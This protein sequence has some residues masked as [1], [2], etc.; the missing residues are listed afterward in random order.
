M[1]RKPTGGTKSLSPRSKAADRSREDEIL[2]REIDDAVRQ[3]DATRFLQKYGV[4]L[5]VVIAF[6]LAAML[7]YW[8]YDSSVEAEY[9]SQSETLIQA[10][11]NVGGRDFERASET[12]DPLLADGTSGART[13]ARFLQ[14]AA[15][16]EQGET[17][18]A[19]ELFATIVNDP[20][21][22]EPLRDLALVRQV[23]VQFD[24]LEPGE[25]ISRLE[26]LAIPGNDFF[27]SAGELV[28][29]AHLEAG[30]R[31]EAGTLFAAI[32]KDEELPE[33]LRSRARQMAGLLGVDAIEDVEQLL[34]QQ[35][36]AAPTV[37]QGSGSGAAAGQGAQP[38]Q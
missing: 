22:P 6:A 11:D 35:Q 21:T 34:E 28:A 8:W 17:A 16:I 26:G 31:R 29:I 33:T 13:S 19:S 10:L 25:V 5:G 36:V 2:M 32:A 27:G 3:D 24:T 9:E 38:P 23:S 1:A 7:A 18:R 20:D 12:V 15:A 4:T 14:A 37:P 30:N